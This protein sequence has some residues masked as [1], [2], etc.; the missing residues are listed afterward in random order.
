VNKVWKIRIVLVVG[1]ILLVKIAGVALWPAS[2]VE[3]WPYEFWVDNADVEDIPQAEGDGQYD[4]QVTVYVR[5]RGEPP[6]RVDCGKPILFTDDDREFSLLPNAS[7]AADEAVM[8]AEINHAI[9]GL[10]GA[11]VI[12]YR[13]AMADIVQGPT[14][15]VFQSAV[16]LNDEPA[17][18]VTMVIG[19]KDKYG[20]LLPPG[21]IARAG[22]NRLWDPNLRSA[23]FS[24]D[25]KLLATVGAESL[26][27]WST[28]TGE[29]L[30][31]LTS[32][33]GLGYP[34]AFSP[35]GSM[36]AMPGREDRVLVYSVSEGKTIRSFEGKH[37]Y[38]VGV[39]FSPD[40]KTLAFGGEKGQVE[41]RDIATG[42]L[43]G[44]LRAQALEESQGVFGSIPFSPDGKA[45][46]AAR[47]GQAV[48]W[49]VASEQVRMSWKGAER[50]EVVFSSDNRLLAIT[51]GHSQVLLWDLVA[52]RELTS[53]K[54]DNNRAFLVFSPDSR[55]F[56]SKSAVNTLA[57]WDIATGAKMREIEVPRYCYALSPDGKTLAAAS[58]GG[59]CLI[60][61][62]SGER[63]PEQRSAPVSSVAFSP[64]GQTLASSSEYSMRVDLWDPFT[65]AHRK[66][67]EGKAERVAFLPDGKTLALV[68]SRSAKLRDVTT[69]EKVPSRPFTVAGSQVVISPDGRPQV[70]PTHKAAYRLVGRGSS[71]Y[72]DYERETKI[73]KVGWIALSPKGDMIAL[74]YE[75]VT[76]QN[77]VTRIIKS[78]VKLIDAK[79]GKLIREWDYDGKALC[80]MAFSPDGKKLATL[81]SRTRGSVWST[82]TGEKLVELCKLP[83]GRTDDGIQDMIFSPTGKSIAIRDESTVCLLD[84][85]TGRPF[86]TCRGHRGFLTDFAFSP[87]GDALATGSG[88]GTILFW[89]VRLMR[90]LMAALEARLGGHEYWLPFYLSGRNVWSG[91]PMSERISE[92]RGIGG[93]RQWRRM[94]YET[95]Q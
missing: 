66:T 24:P 30:R 10:R 72:S 23:A 57:L 79:T 41:L 50:P 74:Q 56:M 76:M 62:V 38:R 18:P 90:R 7:D 75:E 6:E 9:D 39:A 95:V 70:H 49:N 87:N 53:L 93:N 82:A 92:N 77:P 27:I 51:V 71:L 83:R 69:G 85:E 73:R 5:Y 11:V 29:R 31:K 34:V 35:D 54:A 88:D 19:S 91:D 61:V 20:D 15:V 52:H 21:A 2:T 64:D 33:K 55:T 80:A 63:M 8:P 46:A 44:E 25:G 67:I 86:F 22:T 60:D 32:Y 17:I 68:N 59:L 65:G 37:G 84:A 13:F 45:L 42:E 40:G 58:R 4:T 94:L 81:D 89:D 48:L 3:Y 12:D 43:T 14:V 36:L 26:H 1:L 28:A 78:P 16:A 47:K